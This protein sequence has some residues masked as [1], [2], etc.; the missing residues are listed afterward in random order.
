MTNLAI[1]K[2]N[3]ETV[4]I[5]K[6]GIVD[7]VGSNG[8]LSF[9]DDAT[10]AIGK[11]G[12]TISQFKNNGFV[13]PYAVFNGEMANARVWTG[14]LGIYSRNDFLI[15]EELQE[16]LIIVELRNYYEECVLNGAIQDRDSEAEVAGLLMV[17][18][19]AGADSALAFR[20]GGDITPRPLVGIYSTTNATNIRD[21]LKPFYLKGYNAPIQAGTIG[22]FGKTVN[23]Y[24]TYLADNQQSQ[25]ESS[26]VKSKKYTVDNS[27]PPAERRSNAREFVQDTRK[28]RSAAIQNL[29][30]TMNLTGADLVKEFYRQVRNGKITY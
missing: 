9:I 19:A 7:L 4:H 6:A 15:D 28:A 14:K 29:K 2:L 10:K 20:Q 16:N 1:E 5:I 18:K 21:F 22:G 13:K 25:F 23:F 26:E 12:M 17:A 11:Y 24:E 8:K 3:P 30:K 27:L